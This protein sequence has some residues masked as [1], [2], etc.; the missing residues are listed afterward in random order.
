MIYRDI[1]YIIVYHHGLQDHFSLR[2]LLI[3]PPIWDLTFFF[4]DLGVFMLYLYVSLLCPFLSLKR[5]LKSASL[6]GAMK[7]LISHSRPADE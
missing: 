3:S 6:F 1:Q 4:I 5:E 7:E 2:H